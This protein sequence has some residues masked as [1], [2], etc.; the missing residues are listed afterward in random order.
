MTKRS[1]VLDEFLSR[2]G[3]QSPG[4]SD[5]RICLKM[6]RTQSPACVTGELTHHPDKNKTVLFQFSKMM[7]EE[8]FTD[9]TIATE[10]E[11]FKVHI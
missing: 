11:I 6:E 1:R 5:R 9:V 2:G 10:T 8:S 4:A 7:S 3:T